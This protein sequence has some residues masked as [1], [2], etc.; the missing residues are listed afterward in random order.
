M[1][2]E[3]RKINKHCDVVLIRD[4]LMHIDNS[5][6]MAWFEDMSVNDEH[7][8]CLIPYNNNNVGDG[9]FLSI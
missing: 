4:W 8:F 3:C 6:Y 9:C 5:G 2:Y 7:C 1:R